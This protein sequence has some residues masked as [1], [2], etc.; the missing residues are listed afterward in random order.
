MCNMKVGSPFCTTHRN[1]HTN[2]FVEILAYSVLILKL[3]LW[4]L[5]QPEN[6]KIII[7]KLLVREIK[8]AG[9][10]WVN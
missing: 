7:E 3:I 9:R 4:L 5:E 10:T 1:L 6:S 2:A 8:V